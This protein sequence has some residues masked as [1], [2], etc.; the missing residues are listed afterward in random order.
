MDN[1]RRQLAAAQRPQQ[2]GRVQ[3]GRSG[4]GSRDLLFGQL[5]D[6]G[7][8]FRHH[9]AERRKLGEDARR[10]RFRNHVD[11]EVG[12][13]GD[14]RFGDAPLEGAA[15]PIADAEGLQTAQRGINGPGGF[16]AY[17]TST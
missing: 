14:P 15:Q 8:A 2:A 6:D 1:V 12:S 17:A 11:V 5:Q 13:H 7:R 4:P 16:R 10:V 3:V 9:F